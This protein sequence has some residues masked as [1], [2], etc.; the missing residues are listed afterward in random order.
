VTK[1]TSFALHLLVADVPDSVRWYQ[2]ALGAT[3]TRELRMPDGSIA[4]ADLDVDGLPIALAAA[5]PGTPMATPDSTSTTV[6]AFR[7]NVADADAAVA[8][9]VAAGGRLS[10]AVQDAF[11]GVRT[12]EVLDPSGH[13]WAFDQV[14]REVPVDEIEAKLADLLA[15]H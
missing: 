7:L 12:G 4:I 5:V 9:A 14:L 8:R 10:A 2:Q 13:R 11:W 3:L 6:A 15:G 1:V